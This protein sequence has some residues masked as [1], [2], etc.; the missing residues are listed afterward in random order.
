LKHFALIKTFIR[1]FKTINNQKLYEMS[2]KLNE[3][4]KEI[5]EYLINIL[6]S[7][8]YF[9]FYCKQNERV[10]IKIIV[11]VNRYLAK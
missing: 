5:L 7:K 1:Q 10:F 8:A 11:T 4:K 2:T 9:T 6:S 3:K